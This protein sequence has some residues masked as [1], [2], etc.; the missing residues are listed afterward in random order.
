MTEL[1]YMKEKNRILF[2]YTGKILVPKSQL[3]DV[4]ITEPLSYENDSEACPYCHLYY[5]A[6]C[7]DCPMHKA[8]N[9]CDDSDNK[10]RTYKIVSGILHS[11]HYMDIYQV[12]EIR[13]LVDKFNE[14]FVR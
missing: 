8:G 1:E 4:K 3:V 7:L 11:K 12:P 5:G 9:R 14:E 6:T 10:Y 2:E 13:S